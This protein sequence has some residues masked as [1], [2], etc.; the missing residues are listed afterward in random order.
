VMDAIR[1]LCHRCLVMNTGR[2][3]ASG[4]PIEVLADPEVIRAYLG[5][6]GDA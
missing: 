4:L 5:D 2:L 3:I 1:S 6:D